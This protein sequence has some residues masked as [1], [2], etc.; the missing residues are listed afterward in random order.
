MPSNSL[1]CRGK[2]PTKKHAIYVP[3]TRVR[4][5]NSLSAGDEFGSVLMGVQKNTCKGVEFF[6]LENQRLTNLTEP[7]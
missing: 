2:K 4:G 7:K 3:R 6:I 1:R 5:L